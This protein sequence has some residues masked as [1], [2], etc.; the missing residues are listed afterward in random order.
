MRSKPLVM[1]LGVAVAL[2]VG[3]IAYAMKN[4]LEGAPVEPARIPILTS[5]SSGIWFLILA[6]AGWLASVRQPGR[7]RAK[8]R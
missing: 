1:G 2:A 3:A 8:T 5:A 6:A 4:T 7:M